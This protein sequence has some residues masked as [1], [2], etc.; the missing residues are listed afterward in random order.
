MF[1]EAAQSSPQTA[2]A[3]DGQMQELF[4]LAETEGILSLGE[5]GDVEDWKSRMVAGQIQ[6]AREAVAV[7]ALTLWHSA[8]DDYLHRLLRLA[9][10]LNRP[11]VLSS[12]T[13]KRVR[14]GDIHEKGQDAAENNVI[15]AWLSELERASMP[16]KWGTVFAITPP[17]PKVRNSKISFDPRWLE[18]FDEARH[19]GAHGDGSVAAT[20]DLNDCR[21]RLSSYGM[22][23]WIQYATAYGLKVDSYRMFG[24]KHP[25]ILKAEAEGRF[26]VP[27]APTEK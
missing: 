10:I 4:D 1:F 17:T 6:T 14:M 19:N 16:K 21:K 7:A 11:R 9:A 26:G 20:F 8:L 25:V 5:Q 27:A 18:D 3:L 24:A 23:L 22:G 2:I 12:L 15:E 13:E